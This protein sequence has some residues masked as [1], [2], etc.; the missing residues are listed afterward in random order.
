M[1]FP[2]TVRD[3]RGMF[4]PSVMARD[5]ADGTWE[6]WLEFAPAGG[7]AV[8]PCLT[9]IETRQHNR[10]ALE[11]WA[12]GLTHVYAEGALA[13]ARVAQPERPTSELLFALEEIVEALDRRLPH[14]E[15]ASE[16]QIATD[17]KRLRAR[18][19]QRIASLRARMSAADR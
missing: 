16:S 5:R 1:Q 18:A 13:R 2:D 4:S 19:I 15:R 3:E 8:G 14:L 6:G 9:E 10:V 11:R 12:S 7:N 17:A